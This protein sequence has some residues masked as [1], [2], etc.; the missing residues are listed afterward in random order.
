MTKDRVTDGGG[1]DI[2]RSLAQFIGEP[3]LL[4]MVQTDFLKDQNLVAD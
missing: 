1:A 2:R 3:D 4:F